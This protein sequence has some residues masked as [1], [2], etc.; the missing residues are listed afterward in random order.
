M[1]HFKF[2]PQ[3]LLMTM[4]LIMIM[5]NISF[6]ICLFNFVIK[7]P[8]R[9]S[10]REKGLILNLSSRYSPSRR[11]NQ[12]SRACI[13][14]RVTLHP[15]SAESNE[16]MRPLPSLSPFIW[17]SS[18]LKAQLTPT[19]GRSPYLNWCNSDNPR[20][21]SLEAHLLGGSKINQIDKPG[22][23]RWLIG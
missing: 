5:L 12:G 20:Q 2:K 21:A 8:D 23:E 17:S 13:H 6:L 4:N 10:I 19:V 14:P 1:G 3:C 9:I 15:Q 22:L 16:C 7:C 11:T 18:A